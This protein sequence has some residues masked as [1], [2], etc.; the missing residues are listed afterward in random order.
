V[1]IF[2]LHNLRSGWSKW[3][4]QWRNSIKRFG[5]WLIFRHWL[6]EFRKNDFAHRL[7]EAQKEPEQ[8][9]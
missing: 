5:G 8:R 1:M 7:S 4:K 9:S 6:K 3:Y 2:W